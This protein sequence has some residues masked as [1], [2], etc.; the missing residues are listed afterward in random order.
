[1]LKINQSIKQSEES[2]HLN[3][4]WNDIICKFSMLIADRRHTM[5]IVHYKSWGIAVEIYGS[6]LKIERMMNEMNELQST[7]F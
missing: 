2:H 4:Q 5:N 1:M 7:L 6:T 3:K